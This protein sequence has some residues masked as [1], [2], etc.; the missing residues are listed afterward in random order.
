MV[1]VSACRRRGKLGLMAGDRG[2]PPTP[3]SPPILPLLPLTRSSHQNSLTL[4]C[5]ST[6]PSSNT[7]AQLVMPGVQTAVLTPLILSKW[8]GTVSW[9]PLVSGSL[10]RTR[11]SLRRM[12]NSG[13]TFPTMQTSTLFWVGCRR[14][15]SFHLP[16]F[17][18]LPHIL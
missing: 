5:G 10:C 11:D 13:R 16:D 1:H 3:T 12:W 4:S 17:P 18:C 9:R 7:S 6:T 2:A 15:R 14:K 8:A